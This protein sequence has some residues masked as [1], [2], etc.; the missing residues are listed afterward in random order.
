MNPTIKDVAQ[1]ANV[2]IATVS[3]VL[4][5]LGG[6][7]DKTKQKVDQTIK[8]LKYQPNAIARGLINKRTQTIG[9]L[10]PDVSSAFS[11]DLL[12]GIDEFVHDRNYSV[13][14]CNTDQDGKRTLKYLQL[15]REKQVDGII[16]SSEVLKKEYYDMLESMKVPVVLVSSQ[17]DFANVPYVKVDDYQ[18]AYDA[19][20]YLITKG[21]R[22]IGMI[23]G[24]KGD[25][26]AGT[27]R[28]EGYRK[29]L[30][31]QGIAFDSR[32]LV[33]GDF[34]YESG[35]RAMEAILR[36]TPE[37]TAVFAASDEMAI[38]A[39]STVTKH[40]MNVPEDISIMGYDDLRLA[41]MV[42][43]PLTTVRQPLYDIG[44][45]A[46]EKLIGMIETGEPAKSQICTH[47]IVER[48]SVRAIT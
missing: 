46:S 40:G 6:Y 7:S 17:T 2:S 24:T 20:H 4:H 30:E 44:M 10:F 42:N 33:Y 9:V 5:N 31:A 35:C 18:A 36:R 13:M 16:F 12:H 21:H 23:S 45:I 47:S 38:G 34:S 3:R 28:I 37:V 11:S 43:P 22:R 48:Q 27:P 25:P 1:K 39:L 29:A 14:V 41:R 19:V 26:I 32:Y 15:L 8:E